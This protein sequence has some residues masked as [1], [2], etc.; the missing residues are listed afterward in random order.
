MNRTVRRAS[1]PG[2]P[3]YWRGLYASAELQQLRLPRVRTLP[4]R[5]NCR[6]KRSH[7]AIVPI[8]GKN[9]AIAR[10][11]NHPRAA[12][13]LPAISAQRAGAFSGER[14]NPHC[15]L[16]VRTPARAGRSLCFM[17]RSHNAHV[18][19]MS[20]AVD[21]QNVCAN[22]CLCDSKDRVGLLSEVR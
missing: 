12:R 11:L 19:A 2:V 17:L 21:F 22:F 18:P 20:R 13:T 7:I 14:S 4:W 9:A 16:F 15:Q 3:C 8:T 1:C 5:P 6:R 10:Y